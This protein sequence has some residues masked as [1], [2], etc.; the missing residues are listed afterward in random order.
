MKENKNIYDNKGKAERLLSCLTLCHNILRNQERM[1]PESAFRELN[2]LLYVKYITERKGIEGWSYYEENEIRRIFEEVKSEFSYEHLFDFSETIVSSPISY[3]DVLGTLKEFDFISASAETGYAYENFVQKVLRSISDEPVIPRGIVEYIMDYLDVNSASNV[4]DP[5]CGY[6]ALLTALSSQYT[7][8]RKGKT[9]GFERDQMLV[10]T[11]KMNL[12]MHGDRKGRIER[13]MQNIYN[14]NHQFDYVI[15]SIKHRETT[16]VDI[17]G[18]MDLLKHEGKAA[19]L[20]PDDILQKDQY[21]DV[22]RLLMER[23]TVM[24]VISLPD[25]AVKARGR[26]GKWNILIVQGGRA[27]DYGTETLFAKVEN[28]GVSSLG[29]SSEKNDFKLIEPAVYEWLHG[30]NRVKSER[31]MWVKLHEL[32]SWNVEAE[33]LKEENRFMSQYPLYRLRDLVEIDGVSLVEHFEADEYIRVTVRKNQHDVILRDRVAAE[34]IKHLRRQFIVRGGQ[35]II[36]RI[37]AKDGAIGIVPRELDGA[38]VSDNFII[39]TIKDLNVDPYYL[40]MVLTSE[41]Y[42]K[43]MKGISRGATMRTYIKNSDLLDIEVPVPKIEKQ[44]EL[45][46]DMAGVQRQIY[47]LEK[48]WQEGIQRFSKELFG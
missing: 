39:L 17:N 10:Q 11:A 29:L 30:G 13:T 19:L 35:M 37:D 8:E 7:K 47:Q 42:Q 48:H 36:S 12:M 33:L 34:K 6:G 2:R 25:D 27:Q 14:Y 16:R 15:T 1:S 28:I 3:R 26:K 24:A 41:R 20:I 40:L 38:I 4:I 45:I 44:H 5:L 9:F 43:V 18:V 21:E 32:E 23:H 31:V 46:G 22:R